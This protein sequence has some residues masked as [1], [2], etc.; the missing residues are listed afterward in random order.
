MHDRTAGYTKRSRNFSGRFAVGYVFQYLAFKG[1]QMVH[2]SRSQKS[3]L[4]NMYQ[5]T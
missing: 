3:A 1:I 4:I 5:R 2:R